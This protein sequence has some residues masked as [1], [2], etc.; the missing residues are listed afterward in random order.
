MRFS[1]ADNTSL[2]DERPKRQAIDAPDFGVHSY[3]QE[4][5]MSIHGEHQSSIDVQELLKRRDVLTFKIALVIFRSD[6]KLKRKEIE[7]LVGASSSKVIRR[8]KW[9]TEDKVI[10]YSSVPHQNKGMPPS[11]IYFGTDRV[12][13]ETLEWCLE[14]ARYNEA[15]PGKGV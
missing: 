14:N 1:N 7:K 8:L 12:S 15:L 4:S 5:G 3:V 2:L 6:S 10:Q 9:L 11:H 13:L